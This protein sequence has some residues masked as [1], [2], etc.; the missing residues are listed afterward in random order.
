MCCSVLQCVLQC[1]ALCGSVLQ[2]VFPSTVTN[3]VHTYLL[4]TAADLLRLPI[5][6]CML[7]SSTVTPRTWLPFP[8]PLPDP[9]QPRPCWSLSELSTVT[10]PFCLTTKADCGR[11]FLGDFK[12]PWLSEDE[13]TVGELDSEP[14]A[15]IT[16]H[17]SPCI[18]VRDTMSFYPCAI[19]RSLSRTLSPCLF[20]PSRPPPSLSF[21]L[22]LV[23]VRSRRALF[24]APLIEG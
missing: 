14:L 18:P 20:F 5:M 19:S 21:S 9:I 16:R 10:Q 2:C 3:L 12:R 23:L 17:I 6:R 15:P 1:V 8:S 4:P 24:P 13:G 11:D 22:S 7:R